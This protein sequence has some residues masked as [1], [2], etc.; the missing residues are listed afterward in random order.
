M[1]VEEREWREYG[2]LK[3]NRVKLLYRV[4]KWKNRNKKVKINES[5]RTIRDKTV[6]REALIL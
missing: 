3:V 1:S 5:K 6:T 4:E 2:E